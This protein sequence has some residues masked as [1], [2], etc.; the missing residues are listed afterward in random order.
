VLWLGATWATLCM[1]WAYG[2]GFLH[3]LLDHAL[4]R[5]RPGA[6]ATRLTR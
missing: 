3:A 6:G 4:G 1:H 5:R 2:V